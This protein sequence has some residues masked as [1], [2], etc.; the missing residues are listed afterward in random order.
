MRRPSI[1]SLMQTRQ[2]GMVLAKAI[3]TAYAGTNLANSVTINTTGIQEWTVP[4]S[5]V[6][7]IEVWGARGGGANGSNYGKGAR[8]KGDFSDRMF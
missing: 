6:Y 2:E 7:T 3:L 8:M 5:G 1:H 4:A